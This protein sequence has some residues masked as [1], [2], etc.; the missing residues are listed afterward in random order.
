MQRQ[1]ILGGAIALGTLL[2]L[3]LVAVGVVQHRTSV[4]DSGIGLL[5]T[6]VALLLGY[7]FAGILVWKQRSSGAITAAMV[8]AQIGLVLGAVEIANH[9]VEAF[10]PSRPFVL[11][12]SPVLLTFALLGTAGAAAWEGTRSLALATIGGVCCAIVATLITL[13]F[14]ISFNLLSAAHVNWQLREAFA[15]S[16]MIDPGGFRVR[17]ILEASSEILVRMPFL[18]VC[19]A[20][21][22]A[23][24]QAW[25]SRESRRALQLAATVLT[26]FVFAVGASALWH[27]NTIERAARPP[28][29]LS[30]VLLS[31]VALCAAYPIWSA[32]HGSA[33]RSRSAENS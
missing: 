26:P 32:L 25:M 23:V 22:G 19:L 7:G 1:E 10:V 16:G 30:G 5:Q 17:N 2:V 9:L 21:A 6:D 13:C 8:G 33:R 4:Q 15:V 3:S 20:F 11:V 29:V 31:G 28:F 14:A 12:I 24:I 18:A 27:A